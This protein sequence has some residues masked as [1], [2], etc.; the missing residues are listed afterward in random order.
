MIGLWSFWTKPAIEPGHSAW[1]SSLHHLLSWALSVETAKKHFPE[2]SLVTDS[3]GARLLVDGIGLSFSSVSLELDTLEDH[4]P[5][6]WALGKLV[7]YG[8]QRSPF[9]HIDSDVYLWSG[10]AAQMMSAPVI[11]Q[12]PEDFTV[13][14]SWYH[15]EK[16]DSLKEAGGWVP[17]EIDWF[18]SL[19]ARQKAE[20]C[21]IMG[22]TNTDFISYYASRAL[23]LADGPDNRRIWPGIGID[24]ILVEQYFLS[25]CYE[26]HR[27]S[28]EKRFGELDMAYVFPSAG[29]AFRP[30]NA[31]DAGYTHL[32]GGAK[33][34]PVLMKKL[35][36]RV[37]RDYPQLYDRCMRYARETK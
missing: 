13:G 4:D 10:L 34:N 19:G 35:E 23:R 31:R 32:I 8:L 20:C 12:N 6:W 1:P 9:I 26:Y 37:E 17:E 30:E 21:G 3:A 16:F 18:R 2:T 5:R 11:V 15:P 33:K 24:N 14:E 7:A 22:G 36:A 25:A 28:P 27:S 29:D